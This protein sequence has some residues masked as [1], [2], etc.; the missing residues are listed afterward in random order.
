LGLDSIGSSPMFPNIRLISR[1]LLINKVKVSWAQKNLFFDC[2]VT[3][4]VLPFLKLLYNL[5]IIRRYLRLSSMK[6]RIFTNWYGFHPSRKQIRFYQ[7]KTPIILTYKSLI[8]LQRS[9]FNSDLIVETPKGLISHR[10]A[11]KL[12][13]GGHLVCLIL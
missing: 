13:T 11:I 8:T 5:G 9:T 6:Y 12:R 10:E 7:Q 3:N 4:S 1:N 2:L